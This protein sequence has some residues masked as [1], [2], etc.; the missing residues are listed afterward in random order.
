MQKQIVSMRNLLN[1]PCLPVE[2]GEKVKDVIQDLKDTL[3]TKKGWGLTANQIGVNKRISY[4]KL[5]PSLSQNKDGWVLINAVITEKA[6]P[7]RANAE[8]CLSFQGITVTTKRYAFIA[9]EYLDEKLEQKTTIFQGYEALAI[10]HEIDHQ[11]GITIFD[12]K[13]VAK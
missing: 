2:K 4:V 3:A 11:N 13:W 5:P 6:E 9:V 8:A 7:F 12:R 10:Q 1:K